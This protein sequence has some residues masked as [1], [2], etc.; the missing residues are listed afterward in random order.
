MPER[1]AHCRKRYAAQNAHGPGNQLLS[2]CPSNGGNGAV[3][4]A[5]KRLPYGTVRRNGAA[6]RENLRSSAYFLPGDSICP[7]NS[8][9]SGSGGFAPSAGGQPVFRTDSLAAGRRKNHVS[10]GFDPAA[11]Y[12]GHTD[13]RSRSAPGAGSSEGGGKHPGFGSLHRCAVRLSQGSGHGAAAQ[14]DESTDDGSGR[15]V[16]T[17][18]A[19]YGAGDCGSGRPG[20]GNGSCPESPAAYDALRLPAAAGGWRV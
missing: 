14:G 10:P 8:G 11:E 13:W 12:P 5:G 16:G 20:A 18:G 6:G 2:L 17:V 15:A 1:T 7:G 4:A 9:G 19:G 3:S